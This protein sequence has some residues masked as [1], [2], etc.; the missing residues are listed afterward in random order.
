[1]RLGGWRNAVLSGGYRPERKYKEA[2]RK[3]IIPEHIFLDS[4]QQSVSN[5]VDLDGSFESV[6]LEFA[7][8]LPAN[9]E[10]TLCLGRQL[11]LYFRVAYFRECYLV[12]PLTSNFAAYIGAVVV[13]TVVVEEEEEKRGRV[14][15]HNL[16]WTTI[17]VPSRNRRSIISDPYI[18]LEIV[19]RNVRLGGPWGRA[20][21]TRKPCRCELLVD[22]GLGGLV[23]AARRTFSLKTS[24]CVSCFM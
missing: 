6:V 4:R 20:P 15:G 9:I 7:D 5:T 13:V 3:D 21:L 11:C 16:T 23:V 17:S 24:S 1:M 2:T 12:D 8:T 14:Y 22:N 18:F 19:E 10:D